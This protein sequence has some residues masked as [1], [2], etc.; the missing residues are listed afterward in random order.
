MKGIVYTIGYWGRT[1]NE[2]I[3]TLRSLD[4]KFVVDVRRFPSSKISEYKKEFLEEVLPKHGLSYVWLGKELGGF[5]RETYEKFKESPQFMEG[6]NK[7][8]SLLENGN[9]AILC[10]ERKP[11]YCHRRYISEFLEKIGFRVKHII[12]AESLGAV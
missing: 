12:D 7:L 5:R 2:L 9:I 4:V 3:E 1:I 11:Q 10:K 8:I 6:I